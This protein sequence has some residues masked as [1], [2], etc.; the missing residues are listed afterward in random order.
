MTITYF[1]NLLKKI[2]IQTENISLN[3]TRLVVSNGDEIS[4]QLCNNKTLSSS[5][6]FCEAVMRSN[7]KGG[8]TV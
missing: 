7:S 5:Y 3:D 4:G 2:T 6:F 1:S 8:I